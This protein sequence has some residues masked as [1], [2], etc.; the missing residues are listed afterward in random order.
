MK[1]ISL[2]F[3][4]ATWQDWLGAERN[5]PLALRRVASAF[6]DLQQERHTADYDNYEQW[7][8]TEVQETLNTVRIAF[9]DWQ[10]I[11]SDPMAGNYLLAMLLRKQR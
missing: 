7:G 4:K 9:Q 11:R 5:V 6:V 10:S 2:Q 8:L 1:T 3:G